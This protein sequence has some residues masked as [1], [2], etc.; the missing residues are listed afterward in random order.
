MT[1]AGYFNTVKKLEEGKSYPFKV[2][3]KVQLQDEKAYFIL[4]DPYSIRHLLPSWFYTKYGIKQGQTINC[5]VDKINC[6]GRV[7][8]E[9]EH[10]NYSKG[11][12]YVFQL[13]SIQINELRR[14]SKLLLTDIFEN[15]IEVD[16][17]EEF[18]LSLSGS[19]YVECTVVRI[20]K[21]KPVLILAKYCN[22][23]MNMK[24]TSHQNESTD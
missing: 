6:T 17:P 20:R 15:E 3:N 12:V 11:C 14:K 9:P 18:V 22:K 7:Y 8:L 19:Q 23:K 2:Y 24:L 13:K 4:E 5:V 10:P 21:G 16:C 1:T